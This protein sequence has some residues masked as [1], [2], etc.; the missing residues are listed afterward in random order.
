MV[1]LNMPKQ[2]VDSTGQVC[3]LIAQTDE[4][5][6]EYIVMLRRNGYISYAEWRTAGRKL[7][8]EQPDCTDAEFDKWVLS[9][10]TTLI[11]SMDQILQQRAEE[12]Q[13][14]P[15]HLSVVK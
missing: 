6:A 9:N 11:D 13:P 8:E 3:E 14:K 10:V 15:S 4:F 2:F 7:M 1:N 12:K 5:L